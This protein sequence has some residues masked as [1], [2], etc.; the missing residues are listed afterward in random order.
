MRRCLWA[1]IVATGLLVSNFPGPAIVKTLQMFNLAHYAKRG[2]VSRV[3]CVE[4]IPVRD[5]SSKEHSVSLFDSFYGRKYCGIIFIR[6]LREEGIAE[7]EGVCVGPAAGSLSGLCEIAIVSSASYE[8]N[9]SN[10]HI[11]GRR[12]AEVFRTKFHIPTNGA[13]IHDFNLHLYSVFI[14][15]PWPLAADHSLFSRSSATRSGHGGLPHFYQLLIRKA[16]IN[17]ESNKC[18]KGDSKR[19]PRYQERAKLILLFIGCFLFAFVNCYAFLKMDPDKW[20]YIASCIIS[21]CGLGSSFGYAFWLF[22]TG[23]N[24]TSDSTQQAPCK[25]SESFWRF[26]SHTNTVPQKYML[27]SPNYWGTVMAIRRT[28]G[29]RTG[30]KES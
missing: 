17:N 14:P 6:L 3:G 7:Y 2:V 8:R 19:E 5:A 18:E 25:L 20:R 4:L 21:I 22:V 29:N 30:A 28:G 9:C 13:C 12:W 10:A 23:S 24:E 1:L 27:T 11:Q 16:G 26:A 15:D